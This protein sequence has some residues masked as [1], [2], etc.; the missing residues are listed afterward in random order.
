MLL[1]A[2]VGYDTAKPQPVASLVTQAL[3]QCPPDLSLV[4]GELLRRREELVTCLQLRN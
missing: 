3:P 1:R 4:E 2:L